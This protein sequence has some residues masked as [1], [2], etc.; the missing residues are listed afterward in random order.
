MML[1]FYCV[2]SWS[3]TGGG[4]DHHIKQVLER[5]SD[6]A[7]GLVEVEVEEHNNSHNWCRLESYSSSETVS[8]SGLLPPAH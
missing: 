5:Q 2:F 7:G 8:Q 4:E 1:M 3:L 6:W